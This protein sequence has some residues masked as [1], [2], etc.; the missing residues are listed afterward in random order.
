MA[1]LGEPPARGKR[2]AIEEGPGS[3]RRVGVARGEEEI[4]PDAMSINLAD[5]WRTGPV[6]EFEHQ[7]A[8][9]VNPQPVAG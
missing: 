7:F 8:A 6:K 3:V 5:S 2:Q 4:F 9:L 1:C